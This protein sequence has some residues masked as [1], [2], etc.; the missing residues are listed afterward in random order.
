MATGSWP[1]LLD[2]ASRLDPEGTVPVIAEIL[3]QCNDIF[4]DMPI[5][6]ANGKTFH[7]FVFRT[8]IPAGFWVSY[9]QGTPYSKS[10]T[11]RARVAIGTLRDYSQIDKLLAEDSG[12]P[13]KFRESEDAAFLQGMSQTIAQ[14]M[15]YGNT[16]VNP[17][18]FTGLATFYNTLNAANAANAANVLGGGGSGSSNSSIWLV[19]WGSESVFG[20][21]PEKSRAGLHMDDKGDVVP[22]FDS[23]GNRFEACTSHFQQ[24]VGIVPKDWRYVARLANL[25]T[26]AAGLAGPSAYDIFVGLDELAL[27]FPKLT[28]KTSGVTKT[29]V[30]YDAPGATRPVIYVNRL[31]KHF[32]QVQAMRNRNVLLTLNDYDGRTIQSY[33]GEIPIKVV[34][35]LLNT[36]ST[37]N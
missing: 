26:T 21:Y 35:Q 12:D 19:G 2:V 31:I 4:D 11:A 32:M 24:R 23:V 18:Q 34:D 9:N 13:V 14:T 17:S 29:D 7:E 5:E 30:K 37:I 1:T 25:D 8:S 36:E 16:A 6:V 15:F 22:G 20:V 28:T 3:S 10:T 27:K 33:R